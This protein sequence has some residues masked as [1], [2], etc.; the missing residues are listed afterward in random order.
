[1]IP[2]K[3][4][5]SLLLYRG[6]PNLPFVFDLNTSLYAIIANFLQIGVHR[7]KN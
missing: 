5:K 2:P 7:M 4:N 3:L 6:S 1:M